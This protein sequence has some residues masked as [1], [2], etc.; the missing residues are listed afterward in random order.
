MCHCLT[1]YCTHYFI[2]RRQ[3]RCYRTVTLCNRGLTVL[4][5]TACCFDAFQWLTMTTLWLNEN[6][7]TSSLSIPTIT[8]CLLEKIFLSIFT[9]PFTI[10]NTSIKSPLS[11]RVSSCYYVIPNAF[12]L[13]GYDKPLSSGSI[14]VILFCTFSNNSMSAQ[15]WLLCL[16]TIF[17][18]R[19]N[20]YFIMAAI[21]P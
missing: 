20:K 15:I 2:A 10:L 8:K 3:I 7:W 14:L 17:Q 1:L 4:Q 16:Y 12:N 5:S 9:K 19:I 18:A 13:S 6:L 11:L 21:C